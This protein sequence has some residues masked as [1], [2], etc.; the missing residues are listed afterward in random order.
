MASV[1]EDLV[2][3]DLR[4]DTYACIPAAAE[5]LTVRDGVLACE[6]GMLEALLAADL[7]VRDAPAPGSPELPPLPDTELPTSSQVRLRDLI[8]C[9]TC[10]WGIRRFGPATPVRD[11]LAA[12]PPRPPQASEV[13]QVAAL[14]AAFQAA[15]PW[16]PGQGACLYRAFL[17]LTLLRRH[18]QNATWVFGVK[19]WPFSAHCWLQVEHQVLDDDPDRVSLYTPIM[20]V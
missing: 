17:L 16:T 9:W 10:A 6:P 4:S 7:A 19:T 3:L 8:R 5:S 15:L 11:L 13:R 14:T 20:A 1:D 12:L 2:I 18:G